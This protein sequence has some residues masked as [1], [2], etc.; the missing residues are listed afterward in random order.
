VL[1][2]HAARLRTREVE[3]APRDLVKRR[4][5][6][7]AGEREYRFAVELFRRWVRQ[8][9]PLRDVKEELDQVEPVAAELFGIGQRYFSQ[10]RWQ[11]A[12]DF[13]RRA[14]ERNPHHFR[15]RLYLG[16]ALLELGQTDEA[17][18]ELEMAYELD[19]DEAGLPL[20]RSLVAQAKAREAGGDQDGARAACERALQISP[21]ERAAHEMLAAIWTRQGDLEKAL[22]AYREAGSAEKIAQVEAEIE[23]ARLFAHGVGALEREAWEQAQQAFAELVHRRPDYRRD[24][25]MAA[26]LLEQA[27]LQR[28]RTVPLQTYGQLL[29]IAI[30]AALLV[31]LGGSWAVNTYYF[32]PREVTRQAQATTQV[33]ALATA[34]QRTA[35]AQAADATAGAQKLFATVTAEAQALNVAA[36]ANAQALDAAATANARALDA[37]ATAQAETMRCQDAGQYALAVVREPVLAP[38]PGTAYVAGASIPDVLTATWVLT[39][40]GAC[41]WEGMQLQPLVG[42]E[43]VEPKLQHDGRQVEPGEPLEVVLTFPSRD[44]ET[45]IDKEWIVVVN[46]L[47]LCDQP[48][49]R[50]AVEGWIVVATPAPAPVPLTP[51][52]PPEPSTLPQKF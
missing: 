51:T 45:K 49:L 36:T 7:E 6:E 3:L 31:L 20:A 42:E 44:A 27:V 29:A 26:R 43:T 48:H 17:V 33:I 38:T 32:Q 39:N 19:R 21:N 10:R 22:G 46:G 14:L 41:P 24:G 50:L 8:N 16:E 2:A 15:A 40:T 34:A 5:L 30:A 9:K 1:T 35:V 28:S 11:D 47:C 18:A 25:Q 23:L 12:V 37:T 13:F 4:V 52:P